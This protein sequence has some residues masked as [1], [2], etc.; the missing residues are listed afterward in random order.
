MVFI[1][2]WNFNYFFYNKKLKRIMLFTCRAQR[3]EVAAEG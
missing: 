1:R 3:K 2:R